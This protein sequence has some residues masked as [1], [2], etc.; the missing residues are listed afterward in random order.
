MPDSRA[1]EELLVKRNTSE[2]EVRP[3]S[4]RGDLR[5]QELIWTKTCRCSALPL[6]IRSGFSKLSYFGTHCQQQLQCPMH[7]QKDQFSPQAV[8]I[9]SS[10]CAANGTSSFVYLCSQTHYLS[11]GGSGQ[12]TRGGHK[13]TQHCRSQGSTPVEES[14]LKGC[15]LPYSTLSFNWHHDSWQSRVANLCMPRWKW[16]ESS[17]VSTFWCPLGLLPDVQYRSDLLNTKPWH[18]SGASL[19]LFWSDEKESYSI[20]LA[21]QTAC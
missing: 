3:A 11:K 21:L 14:N 8:Q 20:T 15:R 16:E 13:T 1:S 17:Q 19:L 4:N 7:A 10:L 5:A 18:P 9:W 12:R 2:E 6:S